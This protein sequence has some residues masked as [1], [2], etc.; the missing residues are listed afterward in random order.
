MFLSSTRG[1]GVSEDFKTLRLGSR[2][3]RNK[4]C[5]SDTSSVLFSS[6]YQAAAT[7][8][9]ALSPA[10]TVQSETIRQPVPICSQ[11][12]ADASQNIHEN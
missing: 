4:A 7:R 2:G 9:A 12:D 10:H 1:Q 5:T 11:Q 3:W 6:P 8:Q